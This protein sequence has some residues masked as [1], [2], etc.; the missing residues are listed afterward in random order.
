MAERYIENPKHIEISFARDAHGHAYALGERDCTVQ[1]RHQKI[2]EESPSVAINDLQRKAIADDAL[3]MIHHVGYVNIGTVEF[4][5]DE[6]GQHYFMEVNTR[7]QVEHVVTEMVFDVDLVACQIQIAQDEVIEL[8]N[9]QPQGHAI[10]VRLYAESPDRDFLPSSGI[11]SHVT[12]PPETKT[13]RVDHNIMVGQHITSMFDPLLLKLTV[14][15][16]NRDEAIADLLSAL[17]QLQLVGVMTNHSFI[18]WTLEHPD[19]DQHKH[20]TQWVKK[21]LPTYLKQRQQNLGEALAIWQYEKWLCNQ[22]TWEQDPWNQYDAT[23]TFPLDQLMWNQKK[24]ENIAFEKYDKSWVS[25]YR[26]YQLGCATWIFF[27]QHWYVLTEKDLS[28][29]SQ[30]NISDNTLQAPMTGTVVKIHVKQGDRV[31]K[32]QI[33]IEMEAMKMQYKLASPAD[34]IVD[35]FHCTENQVVNQDQI[36]VEVSI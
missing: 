30:T 24:V 35:V 32:D 17:E 11:V 21:V 18:A 34:G 12:L 9:L 3:K 27:A 13:T 20:H 36:L 25:P 31:H 15:G 26:L 23:Y 29:G 2:I 6:Q 14:W 19:F 5:L 10:E 33:L 1:R 4:L 22:S 28:L 16:E 7:L 8:E